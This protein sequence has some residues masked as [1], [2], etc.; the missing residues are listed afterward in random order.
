M[1]KGNFI[2][3]TG[4]SSIGDVTFA[5][6]NGQQIA[7]VRVRKI[8]NPKSVGQA[9]QR[10]LSSMV[11]KFYSPLS[12]VL[13]TSFEGLSKADSYA[14]FLSVNMN[15]AKANGWC[16]PKG[17]YKPYPFQISEGTLPQPV[18]D[19]GNL[20]IGDLDKL[21]TTLG[22]LSTAIIAAYPQLQNG[23]QVTVLAWDPTDLAKNHWQVYADRFFLDTTSAA[24]IPSFLSVGVAGL[25]HRKSDEY[26]SFIFSRWDGAKWAR[27]TSSVFAVAEVMETWMTE[28]KYE[29]AVASFM[30]SGGSTPVSDVYLNGSDD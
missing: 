8:K 28:E 2:L 29:E 24:D 30:K 18:I 21:P 15:L 22:E 23:D 4:T 16:T 25:T 5:R 13:E 12:K 3:G 26:I 1:G 6:R 27:S 20:Q 10:M 17:T 14:K 9:T 7:R 11:V 19:A